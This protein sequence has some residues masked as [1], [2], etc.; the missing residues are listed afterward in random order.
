M[1]THEVWASSSPLLSSTFFGFP[2]I[3]VGRNAVSSLRERDHVCTHHPCAKGESGEVRIM[4]NV[5]G[6]PGE[7]AGF[8]PRYSAIVSAVPISRLILGQFYAGQLE[9]SATYLRFGCE[10]E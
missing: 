9:R 2:P 7:S 5:K 10:M 4:S 6:G 3:L 8:H 1:C